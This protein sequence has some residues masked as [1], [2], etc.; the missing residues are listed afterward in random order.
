M[1]A[2]IIKSILATLAVLA[3][4]PVIGYVAISYPKIVLTV[5]G[6]IWAAILFKM[7]YEIYRPKK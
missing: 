3:A 7:F 6:L 2:R 1:N 5:S 4:V